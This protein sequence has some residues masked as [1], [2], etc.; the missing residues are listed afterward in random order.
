LLLRRNG[1]SALR[2]LITDP[3]IRDLANRIGGNT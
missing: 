1:Q 2:L 3:A